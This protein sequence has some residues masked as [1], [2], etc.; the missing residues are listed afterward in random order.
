M[1]CQVRKLRLRIYHRHI[2]CIFFS[3]LILILFTLFFILCFF[4][5]LLF[6][7]AVVLLLFV[8]YLSVFGSFFFFIISLTYI[9]VIYVF[10]LDL[11]YVCLERAVSRR[12]HGSTD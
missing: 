8:N 7:T 6:H 4:L 3:F 12:A 1:V 5:H 10:V 11:V 2:I 9:L